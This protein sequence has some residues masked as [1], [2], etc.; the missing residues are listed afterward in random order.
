MT[1]LLRHFISIF[2]FIYLAFVAQRIFFILS[3]YD[4]FRQLNGTEILSVFRH[5][6]SMDVASACATLLIP[7]LFCILLFGRIDL[8][9]RWSRVYVSILLVLTGFINACDAALFTTWGTRI[10]HQAISYLAY[11]KEAVSNAFQL[12]YFWMLIA[13]IVFTLILIRVYKKYFHTDLNS[14]PGI[15]G[16]ILFILLMGF[17][18]IIGIRGG[19]QTFPLDRSWVYFS[20]HSALNQAAVNSTWNFIHAVTD[21]VSIKENPYKFLPEQD[22]RKIIEEMHQMKDDSVIPFL[23][24]KRP[25]IILVML[26]S[27]S[28]DVMAA[29]GGDKKITPNMNELCKEGLL[30]TNYYTPGFRTEQGLAA[31]VSGFPSQ[32]TTTIIRQFGKFDKLPSIARTLD[33]AGYISSYY[34]GGN[35][36]FAFTGSYLQSSGFDKIIG[37]NDFQINRKTEWGAYDEE[38]FRFF[39]VDMKSTAQPFFSIIMTSTNHEPFNANVEKINASTPGDW[40][41]DYI[42]TI[43][44]TDKCIGEFMADLKKQSWYD[45]TLIAI[46]SD[47]AH[48]CPNK[49]EYN[50]PPRHH[51]PLLLLGGALKNEYIGKTN[52]Q[53]ASQVDFPATI[54]SQL[55][56]PHNQFPW[57]KN[58]FS[59]YYQPFAYYAFDD[60]FGMVSSNNEVVYDHKLKKVILGDSV[61]TDSLTIKGK[62]YL[63]RLIDEYIEVNAR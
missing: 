26:E 29:F 43:H 17:I 39:N 30:F 57:S 46:V 42:N 9:G 6:V 24:T 49:H 59:P 1:Q 14:K 50:S 54:L 5:A 53:V 34:Y 62:A 22:A 28:S 16:K 63:Q 32:P 3:S 18:L 51:I 58:I 15:A 31:L 23:N 12:K 13:F 21:P 47:H 2:I 61:D 44:Y 25:N 38:L 10:N 56:L 4:N 41:G 7:L 55:G 36:H 35:L 45:N 52:D 19:F 27:F 60:G 37:E 48:S 33:S 11:P 8:L 40:C 20:R